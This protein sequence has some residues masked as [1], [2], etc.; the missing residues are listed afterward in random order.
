MKK[1]ISRLIYQILTYKKM[2]GKE[3]SAGGSYSCLNEL[4]APLQTS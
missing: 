3:I 2:K 4:P 1:I